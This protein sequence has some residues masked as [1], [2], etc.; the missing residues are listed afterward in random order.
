VQPVMHRSVY[1]FIRP[2]LLSYQCL[3]E[4]SRHVIITGGKIWWVRRM[5]QTLK[6]QV[7]NG[8]LSK[9]AGM[10]KYRATNWKGSIWVSK[11]INGPKYAVVTSQISMKYWLCCDW[12]CMAQSVLQKKKKKERDIIHK[13]QS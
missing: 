10:T 7:F 5:W 11:Y 1:F 9:L 4:Q 6:M 8:L 2:E 3:L 13:S 12:F